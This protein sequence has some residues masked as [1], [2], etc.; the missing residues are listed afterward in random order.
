MR[1]FHNTSYAPFHRVC[2]GEVVQPLRVRQ[3]RMPHAGAAPG[4]H[5]AAEGV[6]I[7]PLHGRLFSYGFHLRYFLVLDGLLGF[8]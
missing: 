4:P 8:L 3:D 7:G 5:P 6:R 2:L 1:I